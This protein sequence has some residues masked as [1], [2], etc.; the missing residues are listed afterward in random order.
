MISQVLS[1]IVKWD[2]RTSPIFALKDFGHAFRRLPESILKTYFSDFCRPA[3][4]TFHEVQQAYPA[5]A[6]GGAE[7]FHAG[8]HRGRADSGFS[9]TLHRQHG[10]L[11]TGAVVGEIAA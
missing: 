4:E 2:S 10:L 7:R 8:G 3:F 5:P 9:G 11:Q 1:A 6:G